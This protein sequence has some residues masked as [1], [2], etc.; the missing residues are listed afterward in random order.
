MTVCVGLVTTLACS[1][2]NVVYGGA[3]QANASGGSEN[4][5]SG[6]SLSRASGG[7]NVASGGT[8]STG[9]TSTGGATGAGLVVHE[10]GTYTSVHASDGHALGGVHH[11]DETLPPWVYRRNF[12][13][14]QEYYF[15]SLPEEPLEQLE[16]PVLYFHSDVPLSVQVG[17]DF[18]EGVVG[19]WYP[20]TTSFAPAINQLTRVGGGRADWTVDLVP[21][22][23]PATFLVVQPD[24]IWAPSRRVDSTPVRTT[25]A[26]GIVESEQ[27]I[28]Y[29]GLAKFAP[30]FRTSVSDAGQITL[31]NDSDDDIQAVFLLRVSGSGARIESLGRLPHGSQVSVPIPNADLALDAFLAA[32]RGGLAQALEGTGL[33]ADEARAMVDTWTRSW[34]EGEGLRALYVAPRTWTDAWLPTSITPAPVSSVRSLVGRVELLT[35]IDEA[36]LASRIEN[37]ASSDEID[38]ASLGRFAEPR[39]ARALEQLTTYTALERASTLLATAHARP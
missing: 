22:A 3:G 9:G 6:G 5:G 35:P 10:W 27:F 12:N 14:P 8:P 25:N 39:L 11:E 30:A 38:L 31:T 2:T 37:A 23:D 33:Y 26:N 19:E 21:D 1:A 4:V 32:A 20:S 34:L 13:N 29:R 24:E 36:A 7:G 17:V 15:E 16:T 18:P 28:F